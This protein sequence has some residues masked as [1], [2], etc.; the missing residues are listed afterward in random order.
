MKSLILLAITLTILF[1]LTS[2]VFAAGTDNSGGCQ[3]IYGGGETCPPATTLSVNKQVKDPDTGDYVDSLG[4]TDPRYTPGDVV[5]FQITVK[6]TS[7]S[8]ITNITVKDVFPQFVDFLSG[9]GTFDS[10]SHT[11][12]FTIDKLS[13]GDIKV[14]FISGKVVDKASLPADE[15]VSCVVN[16]AIAT[17]NNVQAQDNSQ[18]CIQKEVITATPQLTNPPTT[19]G[20]LPVFQP[21][22]TKKTPPT[23]PEDWAVFGLLP[24]GALGYWL[25]KRAK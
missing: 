9:S 5:P 18:F 7:N 19:K 4:L 2:P 25:R 22:Q 24:S 20:G 8:D 6:N 3:P 14:F 21:T 23:G 15:G 11:L 13:A 17:A 12:S 16:Q 10:G 1:L